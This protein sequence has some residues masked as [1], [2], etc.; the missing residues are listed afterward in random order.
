M[1]YWLWIIPQRIPGLWDF[2]LQAK[3]AA[4]EYE[5]GVQTKAKLNRELV[6][7]IEIGDQV[8]AYLNKSLVGGVGVVNKSFFEDR[9]GYRHPDGYPFGQRIGVDWLAPETPIDV[10]MLPIANSSLKQMVLVAQTIHPIDQEAFE[11]IAEAVQIECDNP[12]PGIADLLESVPLTSP[13]CREGEL[14]TEQVMPITRPFLEYVGR[15]IQS[16]TGVD[17]GG[18]IELSFKAKPRNIKKRAVTRDN[19]TIRGPGRKSYLNVYCGWVP[20]G[21]EDRFA[22]GCFWWGKNDAASAVQ[23]RW[24]TIKVPGETVVRELDVV[25]GGTYC[26]ILRSLTPGE[27]REARS[28]ELAHEIAV[29]LEDLY[30]RLVDAPPPSNGPNDEPTSS[31]ESFLGFV[32]ERGFHF[33]SHLVV[34][35]YLSL[36]TKPFVILTGISGTGKTKLAQ[37]FAD[38]MSPAVAVQTEVKEIP[39]DD[40]ESFYLEVQ[41]SYLKRGF[42]IPRRA[43][44]YFSI[45]D[46][47][48]TAPLTV[49][50]GDIGG[51]VECSLRNQGRGDSTAYVYFSPKKQVREWLNENFEPGDTLQIQ[52]MDEGEKGIR[53]RLRKLTPTSRRVIKRTPRLAFISVRPDWTDNRGLLGFYN[54]IT[55]TYQTTDFL[56][57]LVQAMLASDQPHFVILD[58]MNLAK[59]EY[60][61]AD[62]LSVL[63]SGYL[64]D[65][66]LTQ[67]SLRLHDLPRCVLAQGEQP[68]GEE[69]EIGDVEALTCH[70]R[71]DNC[72]LRNGV[73]ESQWSRG[74]SDY[75]SAHRSGFDPVCYV[76]PRLFV[77]R[78]VY[79]SGT[80]NVDETTYMFSP[81]VL[82][83]AN[84]IEFNEVDLEG[85]FV[86][87]AAESSANP[88]SDDIR[89]AFT[90]DGKFAP[91]PKSEPI[92]VDEDLAPYRA[93]L[94]VLNDLLQ[95]YNMHFGYRVVDEVLL[96]LWNA[97]G[98]NDPA[99][100]LEI[101]FDHQL[102]QKVLP[103]FHGSQARLQEP[104][105]QLALFCIKPDW[106]S[107]TPDTE[108]EIVGR[109][110]ISDLKGKSVDSLCSEG[111]R[112]PRAAHKIRR[113]L[114]ALE[115][116]GFASFA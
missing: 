4:M 114:D 14:W 36:Q 20:K 37:L 25:F 54:L 23:E 108:P 68:W 61:F 12:L 27:L 31:I 6:G 97:K 41:P 81:K 19:V 90:F 98:L 73:D 105:E 8:V 56:R 69:A 66:K 5:I 116:E 91:L 82:D 57:L 24:E 94:I 46:L 2:C 75:D 38:W 50:L 84:T 95:P 53:Y 72:P 21:F 42:V 3:V 104:L 63:E 115:K 40:S 60:Y 39:E 34:S 103:K 100:D 110:R 13:A 71:C 26:G 22:W 85:Y 78:N 35:Y 17:R 58:E 67:S 29:H 15:I 102:C 83:R 96:Y 30:E 49:Q 107:S 76:P 88:A 47:N 44:D 106:Q 112:Y 77:P 51:T 52:A 74:E 86:R 87:G 32:S 65:G 80:V 89:A 99:F 111:I 11:Q 9:R 7:Q 16:R 55:H 109:Q 33:P 70:V 113:M 92:L 43:Y 45:P 48:G 101:A 18:T 64:Q 79:F 1:N 10:R 59:V 93:Q 62:F 28:I